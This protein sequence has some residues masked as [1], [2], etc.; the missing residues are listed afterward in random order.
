M[1]KTLLALILSPACLLQ[2]SLATLGF[3]LSLPAIQAQ[4]VPAEERPPAMVKMSL[5]V[6]QLGKMR[7]DKGTRSLS[8]PATV[9]MEDGPIEYLLVA[10]HGSTHESL[11]CTDVHASD[12]HF[13]MLL[14]G[15]KGAPATNPQNGQPP[16]AARIDADSLRN[17]PKPQGDSIQITVKWHEADQEKTGCLIPTPKRQGSAAHGSTQ[18]PCFWAPRF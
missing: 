5:G 2:T 7:L 14:L 9:N 17:A 18:A 8:C 16:A 13:A 4:E 15:A 12:I 10:A 1:S 11:L 3:L 6:Y